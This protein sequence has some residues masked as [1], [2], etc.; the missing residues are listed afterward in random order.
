MSDAIMM[1]TMIKLSVGIVGF[2]VAV[3]LGQFIS[4]LGEG[5]ISLFRTR[6]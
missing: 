5:F 2:S 3:I 4:D 6:P 1:F